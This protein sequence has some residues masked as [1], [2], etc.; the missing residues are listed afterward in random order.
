MPRSTSLVVLAAAGLILQVSTQA[1]AR[2]APPA[3]CAIAFHDALKGEARARFEAIA[4]IRKA[5][6]TGRSAPVPA[7]AAT[8][9]VSRF[10][11]DPPR[12][13]RD[14][15]E[16]RALK[17]AGDLLK[18]AGRPEWSASANSRWIVDR[19]I[20]DLTDFMDQDVTPFMCG[21][22][23]TYV[24]T[25]EAYLDRIEGPQPAALA[26]LVSAQSERAGKS[27]AAAKAAM[28]PVPLPTY[29]PEYRPIAVLDGTTTEGAPVTV[30]LRRGMG[31]E[32]PGRDLTRP[33]APSAA[34]EVFGP[35]FDPALPPK[36]PMAPPPLASERDRIA[37][38]NAL[39]S[40]A[41]DGGFLPE[42]SSMLQGPAA[43]VAGRPVLARLSAAKGALDLRAAGSAPDPV[44]YR[45]L[46]EALSDIELVD[47]LAHA[48]SEGPRQ[49][50][51]LASVRATFEAILVAQKTAVRSEIETAQSQ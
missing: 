46:V 31:P 30:E 1:S 41:R 21:G 35:P 38:I 44:A 37:A 18:S 2:N 47:H 51:L 12:V 50:P 24:A 28:R 42:R 8:G 45:G 40:L 49:D 36:R 17:T 5:I 29:A 13:R 15:E 4:P 27:L 23:E 32:I 11:F 7:S 48:E 6:A 26:G 9:T 10:V 25:L 14:K 19:V 34:Q 33:A 16:M 20:A 39:M 22:V 43:G 3:A